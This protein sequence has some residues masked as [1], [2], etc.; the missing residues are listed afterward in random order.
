M[1]SSWPTELTCTPYVE[2]EAQ[3]TE[4]LP[5]QSSVIPAVPADAY[6]PCWSGGDCN[7]ELVGTHLEISLL[8]NYTQ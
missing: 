7:Q 4:H 3:E 6:N 2:H 5:H 1:S 8:V